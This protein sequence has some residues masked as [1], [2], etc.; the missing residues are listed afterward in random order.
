MH[1]KAVLFD[2]DGVIADTPA[3]NYKAWNHVFSNYNIHVSEREYFLLEGH[4]PHNISQILCSNH[5]L[6]SDH[7]EPLKQAK[8]VYMRSLNQP[9]IYEDI[10]QILDAL[11]SSGIAIG[12][13]TGASRSRIEYSLPSHLHKIFDIIITSDDVRKTKPDPEPYQAAISQLYLRNSD[14]IV[15]ENA[16]LGIK[17]AKAGGFYCA[18]LTTTLPAF[19]LKEADIKFLNHKEL[20]VWLLNIFKN[21]ITDRDLGEGDNVFLNIQ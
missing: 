17:S 15:I 2:Y 8:E 14:A 5:G 3:L 12:L 20:K 21:K 10:P 19:D 13:V 4:G 7:I 18:A 9:K 1:L 6:S 16:P 11:K